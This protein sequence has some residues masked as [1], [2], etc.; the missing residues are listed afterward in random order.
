[1]AYRAGRWFDSSD[2]LVRE[3]KEEAKR[4]EKH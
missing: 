1:M 2:I 3:E 4:K